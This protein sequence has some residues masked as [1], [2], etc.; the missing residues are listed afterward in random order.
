V[1]WLP[2]RGVA[3]TVEQVYGDD[4]GIGYLADS[5]R[6]FVDGRVAPRGVAARLCATGG[7][8]FRDPARVQQA[9]R[10]AQ[11]K[12]WTRGGAVPVSRF[13][14]G[15]HLEKKLLC[16]GGAKVAFFGRTTDVAPDL[17]RV[18]AEQQLALHV[19]VAAYPRHPQTNYVVLDAE[20]YARVKDAVYG[21]RT[22]Q[23][24]EGHGAT[25][26]RRAND[27]DWSHLH[28]L[29]GL[30]KAPDTE[31][32]WRV[33]RGEA[34][35]LRAGAGDVAARVPRGRLWG[36]VWWAA[37]RTSATPC[38]CCQRRA[39]AAGARHRHQLCLAADGARLADAV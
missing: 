27:R 8:Q 33:W 39:D 5:S 14:A 3:V 19:E 26:G 1:I 17:G 20:F 28:T 25:E 12:T 10:T 31:V 29:S 24:G 15:R 16:G 2:R 6:W 9:V 7:R 36:S 22:I 32:A 11:S 38:H 4:S 18:G 37:G 13:M 35:E 23:R 34:G 30:R 21:G